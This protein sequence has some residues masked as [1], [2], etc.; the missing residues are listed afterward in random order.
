MWEWVNDYGTGLGALAAVA[1]ALIAVVA[2]SSTARDSRTRTQPMVTADFRPPAHSDS[3][4]E[5]VVT[6]LGPTPARD[7]L[8]TFDPP[9]EMPGDTSRLM[10][11]YLVKRYANP[12]KILNPGQVLSNTWWAGEA[13]PGNELVNREPTPDQVTVHV[14]YSGIG[15]RRLSDSFSLTI[16]TVS[17]TTYNVS[18]TSLKGRLKTI[19]A[20]LSSIATHLQTIA[21]KG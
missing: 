10:A 21:R 6:N 15:R 1:A 11:P 13:G 20:S 12:I 14:E 7:V 2:L 19:N 8:V 3:A 16:E 4:I 18:S 9:L 17:L 5:L